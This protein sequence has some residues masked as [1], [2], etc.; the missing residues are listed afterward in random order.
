MILTGW[1]KR[2]N[3]LRTAN[4]GRHKEYKSMSRSGNLESGPGKLD[5]KGSIIKEMVKY[6]DYGVTPHSLAVSF[7]SYV[8]FSISFHIN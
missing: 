1:R 3:K 7:S 8:I 5:T 6:V 2:E 4:P